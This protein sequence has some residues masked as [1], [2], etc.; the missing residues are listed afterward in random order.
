MTPASSA[1]CTVARERASS[2][3]PSI[4]MGMPPSPIV[5]TL[6]VPILR[7]SMPLLTS[8]SPSNVAGLARSLKRAGERYSDGDAE[9]L[10]D[11]AASPT[12]TGSPAAASVTTT[13]QPP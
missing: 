7:W 2:G 6:A 1:A 8:G 13:S 12:S 11:G 9:G 10:G 3:L 5:L 4:D